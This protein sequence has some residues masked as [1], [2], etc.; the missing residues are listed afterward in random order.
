[1]IKV[2]GKEETLETVCESCD[3][4]LTYEKEDVTIG[5]YGC[6]GFKCPVCGEFVFLGD[7]KAMPKFPSTFGYYGICAVEISKEKTDAMVQDV[8]ETLKKSKE[9]FDFAFASTGDTL[10]VGIKNCDEVSFWVAKNYWE[11]TMS[12]EDFEALR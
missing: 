8:V 9:D 6:E 1:M 2:V 10:V 11:D 12:P 7:R 4:H 5:L 3:S